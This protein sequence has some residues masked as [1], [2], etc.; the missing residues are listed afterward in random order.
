MKD[1]EFT[2][3]FTR[4]STGADLDGLVD[5][6]FEQGCDDALVG[7][8]HPGRIALDFTRRANSAR[9]AVLSAIADVRRA[10]PEARLVEVAPDLVG[11]TD[12]AD[13]VGCS[14]QNVRQLMVNSRSSAPAPVHEGRQAIWHLAPV[15][16]WLVREKRY[17]VDPSLLELA[18]TTMLVNT[19]VDSMSSEPAAQE[20]IRALFV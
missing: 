6:R 5:R 19:T 17:V 16:D 9:E 14:R 8:G 12:V 13:L 11:A 20:E 3:R 2:L 18:A 10:I 15:L 1:Y 4:V 7:V